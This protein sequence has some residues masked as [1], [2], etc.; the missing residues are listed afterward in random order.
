MDFP[1]IINN[2][3]G[4]I[5]HHIEYDNHGRAY[6]KFLPFK[7]SNNNGAYV[8]TI[9][10]TLKYTESTYEQSPLSRMINEDPPGSLTGSQSFYESNNINDN[11]ID[12]KNGGNYYQT[13]QLKKS[14]TVDANDIES[15]VY[16]DK[17]GRKI[18]S[19]TKAVTASTYDTEM[20]YIYDDKNRLS[21][22]IP[23]GSNITTD[24]LNYHYL[25][26]PNDQI[27]SKKIPD[28]GETKY[29]YNVRKQL[30]LVQD[31]NLSN[32]N[33][34]MVTRYDDYGREIQSGIKTITNPPANQSF[35]N[36]NLSSSD[37]NATNTYDATTHNL[38]QSSSRILGTNDIL[39]S[40]YIYDS[41]NRLSTTS[42]NTHLDLNNPQSLVIES[43]YNQMSDIRELKQTLDVNGS[44]N[45]LFEKFWYDN[46]GRHNRYEVNIDNAGYK[47]VSDFDY[48]EREE[49]T[50]HKLGHNNSWLQYIDYSY[51]DWGA[52]K[53]INSPITM[54]GPEVELETGEVSF[55]NQASVINRDLFYE[56]L[57]Y[58][59]VLD[60]DNDSVNDSQSYQNG[61]ISAIKWQTRGRREFA[62]TYDYDDEYK[63]KSTD[64]Y[65][66]NTS[67]EFFTKTDLF[68]TD[69]TYSDRG[70]LTNVNRNNVNDISYIDWKDPNDP[71]FNPCVSSVNL[72]YLVNSNQINQR[73]EVSCGLFL[74]QF[75]KSYTY[76]D[77]GNVT[78][79]PD[80]KNIQYNHLNL[81]ESYDEGGQ[82]SYAA[83]YT[84]SGSKIKMDN[85]DNIGPFEFKS[86][87][88]NKIYF[89]DGYQDDS[90]DFNY[91]IK[92]HL[93]NTRIVFKDENNDNKINDVTDLTREIHYFP[94]GMKMNG[95]WV[96][97]NYTNDPD[98]EY[99]SIEFKANDIQ[100]GRVGH[101]AQN[102]LGLNHA[103]YRSL[104]PTI[105]MWL[106]IDPKAE[107]LK[108]ISPYN[109][110]ANNPISFNDPDGDIIPALVVGA[111]I[112]LATNGLGNL[113]AGNN[114]FQGGL[115]A[116]AFGALGGGVSFGIGQ[117]AVGM[118]GLGKAAFQMGAHGLTGGG[119]SAAQGGGFGSGLL[120]GALSSGL[121]SGAGALGVG[122]TG[123]IGVGGLSGGIGSSIAGGSFWMG[124]RQGLLTSGLNHAAHSGALGSNV[125]AALTTGRAR[126]FLGPDALGGG[127][128]FGGA[129]GIGANV[130]VGGIRMMRGSQKGLAK[131]Y[132]DLGLGGGVDVNAGLTGTKY[133]YSGGLKHLTFSNAFSGISHQLAISA[134]ALGLDFSGNVSRSNKNALG[135]RTYSF[136]V[137][138]GLSPSPIMF[139]GSYFKNETFLDP[140][141]TF[142]SYP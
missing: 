109:S 92:D 13:G 37:I 49:I 95:P 108:G 116:A 31:A 125:A 70:R 123:M 59:G 120:S 21:E 85:F 22:V 137:G 42:S 130:E 52:L 128:E 82:N 138:I 45:T 57:Y 9:P 66:Q 1:T 101:G 20:Y 29:V 38:S 32:N 106:Q 126:H 14:R 136:G 78:D 12:Y 91:Y 129:G 10:S 134:G 6:K 27:Y 72:S 100:E 135:H 87:T 113:A 112:G 94:F 15:I 81:I 54:K 110:M 76:D 53:A 61:N 84:A 3:D 117:A 114:F 26:Y 4:D 111:A 104:D 103:T 133:Y 2:S 43:I 74:Q 60:L 118:S 93:G 30:C 18:L 56:E 121:S 63:L 131:S 39:S 23:D 64:F 132:L 96:D 48:N 69:Y 28:A 127:I 124:A 40:T 119:M 88:L 19:R 46:E 75:D 71:W 68:S 47:L 139:G 98:Y 107:V 41:C 77:N 5:I 34:W 79:N 115:Q 141:A 90:G 86:G 51:T 89:S 25:Y 17:L 55:S 67:N 140:F 105:G 24:N 44:T 83:T 7:V 80:L 73:T 97:R 35:V 50:R 11:V 102:N 8:S 33:E 65:E 36:V 62:Y 99:N 122:N 142:G 16:T 58:D